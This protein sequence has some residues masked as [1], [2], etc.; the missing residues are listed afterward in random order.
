MKRTG[1]SRAMTATTAIVAA[2][3]T[4]PAFAQASRDGQNPSDIIVTARRVEE[5][6][7]DVPISITVFNQQQISNRNIVTAGDLAA[8][9]PSLSAN[10]FFGSQNTAFAIRGFVQDIGTPPSVGVYFA[11]V[12][13]PRAAGSSLPAGDGA[14]PGSFFDLQNVQVLKGPQGT[15]FG[16]NTTGGA[17]LLVP[18]KPTDRFGGYVEGSYGNYDMR[19][20]QAVANVPFG[21]DLG[22]FRI[23]VDRQKR[24]GYLRN[25]G[26]IGPD[27]FDDVDYTAIRASL[28]ANLT[29]TLENYS[30]LSYT[31]S[32]TIGDAGKLIACNPASFLGALACAQINAQRTR[33][34]GFY[35]VQTTMPEAGSRSTQ[36]Q[37]INTTTWRTEGSLTFKNIVSYAQLKQDL[38]IPLFATQFD[39]NAISPLLPKGTLLDFNV[40][41]A[42]PGL[43]TANQDTFS[44]EFQLHG[45]VGDKRLD[46]QAGAYLETSGP[47]GT[48][49]TLATNLVH[50]TSFVP[51]L[52]TNPLGAGGTTLTTVHVNFHDVGLYAQATY[53]LTERLKATAGFRYTWD[54]VSNEASYRAF[55]FPASLTPVAPSR[56]R[57][58][59]PDA[60]LPTCLL[61]YRTSSQ[62]P[63]WLA[64]LEYKPIGDLLA[65]AKYARGYRAGG[66]TGNVPS[67]FAIF[68]PEKVDSFEGGIKASFGGSLH[69]TFDVSGFYNDFTNQ[70][71]QVTFS[72][73]SPT[74]GLLTT[75]GIYN[76]GR[77]RIY[78]AEIEAS[79]T[80]FTGFSLDASYAYINTRLKRVNVGQTP[81]DDPFNAVAAQRP[82]DPLTYTPRDKYSITGTY[83]LP[84]ADAFGRIA[85][86]ATFTHTD[87]QVANYGSRD[88]AGKVTGTSVL[89]PRNLLNLNLAWNRVA[90]TP[91]DVSLF[92][93]NLT[94]DKYYT[95][96]T[97]LL[98]A[99]GFD[100]AQ[101]GQ[102][103]MFGARLRY[104]F[105]G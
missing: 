105:G 104:N 19:R 72:P 48:S 86:S 66:I 41:R 60:V 81:A 3:S 4:W 2:T 65:Y 63:T 84:V 51:Q 52:C 36:W 26:G 13:A 38:S 5:R 98:T 55:S 49:G 79:V 61:G 43:N 75:S 8:Y 11:D 90:E 74:S 91:I 101:V 82:G 34:D 94:Q 15:L 70:Q 23:G 39:A 17:V 42:A 30:I 100:T 37:L 27:R 80:P 50:C 92:V 1:L 83:A 57:C 45:S 20:V 22:A 25:T 12:V 7:Q 77:S 46:Y 44:E 32:D 67:Q 53:A 54:H 88:A 96:T 10:M 47:L 14:G 59:K 99:A 76:A 56:V 89:A 102:P 24:D 95:S 40:P 78:G 33:G 9:T 68:K 64:D 73:K 87:S 18:R 28:V 93:T 69:G 62:A 58:A 103:R 85:I 6:L 21:N 29:S 16:R 31:R 35:S 97:G 71:L